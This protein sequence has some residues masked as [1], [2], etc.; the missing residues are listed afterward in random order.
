MFQ[1]RSFL[2]SIRSRQHVGKDGTLVYNSRELPAVEVPPAY[3]QQYRKFSVSGIREKN[4]TACINESTMA[5]SKQ[6]P[7]TD[8]THFWSNRYAPAEPNSMSASSQHSK[9]IIFMEREALALLGGFM[10]WNV[11]K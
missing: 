11:G 1:E 4:E 6:A 8:E 9:R 10:G 5:I 3:R 7:F 2:A